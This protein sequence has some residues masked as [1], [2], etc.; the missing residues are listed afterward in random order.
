MCQ[1]ESH[2][3]E[4]DST[5]LDGSTA[6]LME[7]LLNAVEQIKELNTVRVDTA[8]L[9][10]E[11]GS[12][13]EDL[14]TI[15]DVDDDEVDPDPLNK[16][17]PAPK[18]PSPR[19]P[20]F[21]SSTLPMWIS[22]FKLAAATVVRRLHGP[23]ANKKATFA[24]WIAQVNSELNHAELHK[25]LYRSSFSINSI[26]TEIKNAFGFS[27]EVFERSIRQRVMNMDMGDHEMIRPLW[28]RFKTSFREAIRL[29]LI[30]PGDKV[31]LLD[32]VRDICAQCPPLEERIGNLLSKVTV[33][34]QGAV[35]QPGSPITF[36]RIASLMDYAIDG[37][38][39]ERGKPLRRRL[40]TPMDKR[41]ED[42][43]E[44]PGQQRP[45]QY[46]VPSSQSRPNL[47]PRGERRPHYGNESNYTSGAHHNNYHNQQHNLINRN[48]IKRQF[49][50]GNEY[51]MKA[52]RV[53]NES[54]N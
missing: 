20:S 1:T 38:E 8:W 44:R 34:Q 39:D 43:R 40:H 46:G 41:R 49:E 10:P 11:Y 50:G 17:P 35:F 48:P 25:I 30:S 54:T 52:R 24:Y 12:H 9:V 19:D 13:E 6:Q 23:S 14:D 4:Y 2:T 26:L 5:Q 31:E 53:H 22:A 32:K 21:R 7:Q 45:Y 36:D 15:L 18:F 3:V 28:Q 37:L 16:L 27:Q 51:T 33:T 29:N 42:N 47:E